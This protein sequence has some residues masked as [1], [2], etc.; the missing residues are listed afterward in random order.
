MPW[1]VGLRVVVEELRVWEAVRGGGGA[2]IWITGVGGPSGR[3]GEGVVGEEMDMASSP[4]AGEVE[5][6]EFGGLGKRGSESGVLAPLV[7]TRSG[8]DRIRSTIGLRIAILLCL[9]SSLTGL[10]GLKRL[11]KATFGPGVRGV[12]GICWKIASVGDG[13]ESVLTLEVPRL[14]A[15]CKAVDRGGWPKI[16]EFLK[17]SGLNPKLVF[18]LRRG[19]IGD[20]SPESRG[21]LNEGLI[22]VA[23]CDSKEG[24]V[25]DWIG[26]MLTTAAAII[27]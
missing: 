1:E 19:L 18:T 7:W 13:N 2:E 10:P 9:P 14:C 3:H 5:A 20:E 6:C 4:S 25:G 23:G 24:L 17:D 12:G 8:R 16:G 21:W 11:L 27:L 26:V 22:G 15:G